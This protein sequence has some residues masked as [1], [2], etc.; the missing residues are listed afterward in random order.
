MMCIVANPPLFKLFKGRSKGKQLL[1]RFGLNS[2]FYS[3]SGWFVL[4]S[5]S[6]YAEHKI[7][8]REEYVFAA[9][10]VIDR[11]GDEWL[12]CSGGIC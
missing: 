1:L 4:S 8:Y 2:Q 7:K 3:M 5:L 11:D 6:S 12:L 10:R 9:N